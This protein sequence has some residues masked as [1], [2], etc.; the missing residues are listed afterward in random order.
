MNTL[1]AIGSFLVVATTLMVAPGP[2]TAL[3]LR[4]SVVHGKRHA[5]ATV[6]GISSGAA[7]WGISAALGIS[8]LVTASEVAYNTLRIAGAAYLVWM[9]VSMLWKT[10]RR[11]TADNSG[12]ETDW[13]TAVTGAETPMRAWR[14]GIT[15]NLLNPKVGVFYVAMLPQFVPDG[16]SHLAMG[17]LLSLIHVLLGVLWF[18][19]LIQATDLARKWLQR[20]SVQLGMDRATGAVLVCFGLLLGLSSS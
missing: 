8:A 6:L 3:V 13:S 17:L 19:L 16:A 7:T 12:E 4:A 18:G 5:F 1:S 20:R 14:R 2:D 15:T 11:V 9:G 10:L